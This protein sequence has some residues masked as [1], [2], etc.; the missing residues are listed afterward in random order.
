M[1]SQYSIVLCEE[2]KKH[3]LLKF[4]LYFLFSS[5][6]CG[7]QGRTSSSCIVHL[8]RL[9]C[10]C[11]QWQQSTFYCQSKLPSLRKRLCHS[12]SNWKIL[13]WKTYHR[14]C[15]W[16]SFHSNSYLITDFFEKYFEFESHFSKLCFLKMSLL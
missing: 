6:C 12:H 2:L 4:F 11:W 1:Y 7:D 8:W 16:F 10:W 13:Q 5:S 14:L 3:G 9:Y 15:M